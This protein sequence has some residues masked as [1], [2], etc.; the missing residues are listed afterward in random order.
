VLAGSLNFERTTGSG[1][2]KN[3][4]IKRNAG[5]DYFKTFKN[6]RLNERT[7]GSQASS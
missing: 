6:F 1:S 3:F 4:R 2:L 5:S 7:N